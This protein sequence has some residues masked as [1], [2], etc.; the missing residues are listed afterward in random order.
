MENLR[1]VEVCRLMTVGEAAIPS[2]LSRIH[3]CG[4]RRKEYI[5]G[6]SMGHIDILM[7]R[8]PPAAVSREKEP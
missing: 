5:W 8:C 2:F 1:K 6:L 3:S 7:L 4:R